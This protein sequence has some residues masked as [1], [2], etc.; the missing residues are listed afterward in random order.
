VVQVMKGTAVLATGATDATGHYSVNYTE[1]G[2]GQLAVVVLSQTA[3]MPVIKVQDNT[4][5]NAIWAVGANLDGTQ[6]TQDLRATHGWTG[7]SY[8][9]A[10][11]VA[12]PFAVLDSMY[13]A[14]KAF[15][16]ARRR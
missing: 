16:A 3:A 11:R 8:S 10:A 1:S 6:T 13:T 5:G 2:T 12:A 9:A 7:T 4:D 15:I 14:A